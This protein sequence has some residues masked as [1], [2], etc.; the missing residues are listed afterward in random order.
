MIRFARAATLL[1]LLGAFPGSASAQGGPQPLPDDDPRLPLVRG[2]LEPLLRGDSAA[3]AAYVLRNA[4]A[5]AQPDTL[6]GRLS[7]IMNEV[8]GVADQPVERFT[9]S[10]AGA[11]MVILADGWA[12][13]VGTSGE[14]PR[15]GT[16]GL[17]R[18]RTVPDGAAGGEPPIRFSGAAELDAALRDR[19][20]SG[21]FSG[22]VLAVRGDAVL[23]ERAYG[24]ADRERG[25]PIR[26][27][28]RFNLG[29][30][31]K[32]F[33]ATAILR[34]AQ[35]G[36]LRLDDAVG[37]HVPELPS[38]IG[39]RVTVRHLL[40]HRSGLWDYLAAPEFQRDQERYRDAGELT[41][42][43]TSRPLQFD[44]GTSVR[45][46]NSG[47]V[48]LGAVIESLTGR[49]YHDV[50]R[51]WILV[52]AGMTSTGPEGVEQ[53][54]NTALGYSRREGGGVARS[55]F[56]AVATPAGGG[57]STA[58]DMRR[59]VAAVAADRL[60]EPRWTDVLVS[61]YVDPAPGSRR[62]FWGIGGGAP[63]I[64][65]MVQADLATGEVVVVLANLDPPSAELVAGS[66]R[67]RL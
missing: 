9:T 58:E 32:A 66:I 26:M 36:A 43:I 59:F 28:T 51:D 27:D 2:L 1:L 5:S 29:S 55:T 48:L 65:A 23:F 33:T 44:P 12:V 19:T 4:A 38:E 63:G 10:P 64:S 6:L 7:R 20:A 46:S 45:Y 3:A 14:P 22:V 47:Y 62:G 11:V 42:L 57:Y 40:Q 41:R 21:L 30:G 61:G 67:G 15:I 13:T 49:A 25:T 34:L 52:P 24:H 17:A 35:E 37:L 54:P 31:N 39:D 8:R 18:L 16:L 53:H 50:I 56:S 60:L